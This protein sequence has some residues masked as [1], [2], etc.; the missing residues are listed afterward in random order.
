VNDARGDPGADRRGIRGW[1]SSG[2]ESAGEGGQASFLFSWG[3][4]IGRV[5]AAVNLYYAGTAAL[6]DE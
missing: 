3:G 6:L 4:I 1:Q 2:V 5:F